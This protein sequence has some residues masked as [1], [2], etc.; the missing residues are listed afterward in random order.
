VPSTGNSAPSPIPISTPSGTAITA[1]HSASRSA[2]PLDTSDLLS[3][4]VQSD[5][6]RIDAPERADPEAAFKSGPIRDQVRAMTL[7]AKSK[8]IHNKGERS[9]LYTEAA[10]AFTSCAETGAELIK[11]YPELKRRRFAAGGQR[12]LGPQIPQFCQKK[13]RWLKKS[14]AVRADKLALAR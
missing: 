12:L 10:T 13:L 14:G 3:G 8:R 5:T 4:L 6:Q 7:L 11:H 2:S 9:K 1:A